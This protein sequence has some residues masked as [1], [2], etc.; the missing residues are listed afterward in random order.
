MQQRASESVS[1]QE[2]N[3]QRDRDMLEA[4]VLRSLGNLRSVLSTRARDARCSEAGLRAD[5][6]A[7]YA[8]WC[9]R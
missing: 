8:T 1:N 6:A 7:L 4:E 5:A 9:C 2:Q 3:L